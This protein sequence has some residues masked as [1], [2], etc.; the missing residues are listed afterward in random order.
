LSGL[1]GNAAFT[2]PTSHS[3][4]SDDSE[5]LPNHRHGVKDFFPI[6]S[7]R[8]EDLIRG[9]ALS[10]RV[11]VSAWLNLFSLEFALMIPT[12]FRF[13]PELSD[14]DFQ[15]LGRLAM[16][17]SHI[18]HFIGNCLRALLDLPMDQAIIMIFPLSTEKRLQKIAELAKIKPINAEAQ[19]ALT[20]LAAVMKGLQIV[21]NDTIHGIMSDDESGNKVF[22]NRAKQR[23]LTKE[24]VFSCEELT[25]YAAHA[26]LSLRYALGLKDRPGARH[27][28]PERPAIPAFLKASIPVRKK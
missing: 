6:V 3:Q 19:E 26:V 14:E 28:L 27:P 5:T 21:R 4:F 7:Q 10:R 17:W 16:R 18:E 11:A 13:E 2:A 15:K 24:Q 25:N 23:Q 20:E 8:A 1:G 12:P 22:H 9:I